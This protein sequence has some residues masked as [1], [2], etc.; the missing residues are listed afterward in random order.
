[1]SCPTVRGTYITGIKLRQS[2]AHEAPIR[3]AHRIESRD[4]VLVQHFLHALCLP[5]L[6]ALGASARAVAEEGEVGD[7][8]V[9]PLAEVLDLWKEAQTVGSGSI[10]SKDRFKVISV[11]LFLYAG[12]ESCGNRCLVEQ[13]C[14]QFRRSPI[15]WMVGRQIGRISGRCIWWLTYF[16]RRKH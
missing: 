14:A 12:E 6:R 15:C 1:M 16:D 10:I 9:Q 5:R 8:D 2:I 11:G 3:D 7:E 13:Y 4:P